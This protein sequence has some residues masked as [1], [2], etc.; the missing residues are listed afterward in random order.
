MNVIRKQIRLLFL[1]LCIG[2]LLLAGCAT[3]SNSGNVENMA[4]R[5]KDCEIE[6]L[7]GDLMEIELISGQECYVTTGIVTGDEINE[8]IYCVNLDTQQAELIPVDIEK[9]YYVTDIVS[10]SDN[11]FAAFLSEMDEEVDLRRDALI[12]ADRTGRVLSR[13]KLSEITGGEDAIRLLAMA[14]GKLLLVTAGCIY[15]LDETLGDVKAFKTATPVEDA[16]LVEGERVI[17]LRAEDDEGGNSKARFCKL[18]PAKG[19]WEKDFELKLDR[20]E[21][22][23]PLVS[24]RGASFFFCGAKGIY[25]CEESG[26]LNLVLRWDEQSFERDEWGLMAALP[27][28]GFLGYTIDRDSFRQRMA[29]LSFGEAEGE[30]IQIVIGG[31][32][33]EQ[34]I[35]SRLLKYNQTRSD[36]TVKV[37]E[38]AFEWNSPDSYSDA[39]ARLY[40][41]ILA[42]NGPDVI[43][44]G[45]LDYGN[46]IKQGYLEKLDAYYEKDAEISKEDLVPSFRDAISVEGSIYYL[47]PAFGLD[48][49]AGK[50]SLVGDS[51]GWTMKELHDLWE[52]K[53]SG[54]LP[55]NGPITF[56]YL[57]TGLV[58]S[59]NVDLEDYRLALE[60][61]KTE[62]ANFYETVGSDGLKNDKV[63]LSFCGMSQPTFLQ[64]MRAAFDE[65][66]IT[67]KG[68]PGVEGSGAMFGITDAMG[69]SSR[70]KQKDAAWD[71]IR[72]LM[73]YDFQTVTAGNIFYFPSRLD[74]FEETL[75][76]CAKEESEYNHDLGKEASY[77]GNQF[78]IT[79]LSNEDIERI[80]EMVFEIRQMKYNGTAIADIVNEE[81]GAYFSGEK[82][83]DAVC[84]V[85]RN[86]IELYRKE[87]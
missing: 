78:V 54:I 17:C 35:L 46:L 85:I 23:P 7:E 4:W 15:C 86:R 40:A 70:S 25:E 82:D 73:T 77:M 29:L 28:G 51:M 49:L 75:L 9:G 62:E 67:L 59:E 44:L 48:T 81:A 2:I 12:T 45:G 80:R 38:Y 39:C 19:V 53:H 3:K 71:V 56:R 79:A 33:M 57:I 24:G 42:G 37:K 65:E 60:M 26:T 52:E 50:T 8:R 13:R 32:A 66:E 31:V 20:R 55:W 87:E 11:G 61:A 74:C 43:Y 63:L 41:D 14:D 22:V 1:W 83:I 68:Y 34:G 21:L 5:I 76:E 36:V 69:I 10:R 64:F 18:D 30:R 27:E 58:Q 6:G 16:V 72:S 47:S 84:E